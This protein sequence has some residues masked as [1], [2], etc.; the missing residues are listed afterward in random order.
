[1][2]DESCHYREHSD[3]VISGISQTPIAWTG[4]VDLGKYIKLTHQG[5][6]WKIRM[7][8]I[9][10][11][12]HVIPAYQSGIL[13]QKDSGLISDK[14]GTGA[15]MTQIEIMIIDVPTGMSEEPI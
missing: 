9:Q 12:Y 5:F 13:L 10:H 11:D 6:V 1:M 8:S 14:A 7:L 15:G 3:E 4:F 2:K